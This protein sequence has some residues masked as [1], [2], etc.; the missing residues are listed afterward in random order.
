[1]I[2]VK[3]TDF[4]GTTS[5]ILVDTLNSVSEE[6]DDYIFRVKYTLYTI[7][8]LEKNVATYKLTDIKTLVS[9]INR[10]RL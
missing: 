2:Y 4:L 10:T 5:C 3:T 1:M 8:V 6:T 9:D 7:A